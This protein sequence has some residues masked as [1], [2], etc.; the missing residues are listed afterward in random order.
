MSSRRPQPSHM[1]DGGRMY[2]TSR[3]PSGSAAHQRRVRGCGTGRQ[4]SLLHAGVPRAQ[5]RRGIAPQHCGDWPGAGAFHG[6]G[7][8]RPEERTDPPADVTV[9]VDMCHPGG[10]SWR[11]TARCTRLNQHAS[12]TARKAQAL[13]PTTLACSLSEHDDGPGRGKHIGVCTGEGTRGRHTSI[14]ITGERWP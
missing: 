2:H 1:R 10:R 13:A 14:L 5:G 7:V 6:R 3:L 8:L 12:N 11:V 9:T 4:P